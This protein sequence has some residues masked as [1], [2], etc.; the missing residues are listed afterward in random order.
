MDNNYGAFQTRS[1]VS[2]DDAIYSKVFLSAISSHFIF[3][4]LME[5]ISCRTVAIYD[6]QYNNV[7]KNLIQL[8]CN[9]FLQLI[10]ILFRSETSVLKSINSIIVLKVEN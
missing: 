3:I 9:D 5:P 10:S 6:M 1:S 7:C 4:F 8:L 2:L